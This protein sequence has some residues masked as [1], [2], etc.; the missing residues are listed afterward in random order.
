MN[1]RIEKGRKDTSPAEIDMNEFLPPEVDEGEIIYRGL[2]K[3][4]EC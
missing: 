1:F 2:N 3:I 4:K